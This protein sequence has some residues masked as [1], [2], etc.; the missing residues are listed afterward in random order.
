[1]LVMLMLNEEPLSLKL[2]PVADHFY[3]WPDFVSY[4]SAILTEARAALDL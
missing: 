4:C 2:Q 3:R 1:M